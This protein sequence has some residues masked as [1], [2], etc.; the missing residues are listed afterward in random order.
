V[1]GWLLPAPF[2]GRELVPEGDGVDLSSHVR[3][4]LEHDVLGIRHLSRMKS[5]MPHDRIPLL[6]PVFVIGSLVEASVDVIFGNMR[7]GVVSLADYFFFSVFFCVIGK[8]LDHHAWA[9]IRDL[10]VVENVAGYIGGMEGVKLHRELRV[11]VLV[12]GVD[13]VLQAKSTESKPD[14]LSRHAGDLDEPSAAARLQM[15]IKLA[16]GVTRV[17]LVGY[18][19]IMNRP[20]VV[21]EHRIIVGMEEIIGVFAIGELDAGDLRSQLLDST[22]VEQGD[23][24]DIMVMAGRNALEEL[25]SRYAR[26]ELVEDECSR[27]SEELIP[28]IDVRA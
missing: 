3:L 19:R 11:F 8:I 21:K 28:V 17:W 12:D 14:T 9:D 24:A 25:S 13:D 6:G 20:F 4:A 10:I 2:R 18:L 26:R 16:V 5:V 27:G 15:G 23:A 1:A 22:Y 7:D